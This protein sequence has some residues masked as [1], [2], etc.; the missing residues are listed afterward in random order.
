MRSLPNERLGDVLVVID[1]ADRKVPDIRSANPV[2]SSMT[3][4]HLAA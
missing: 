3:Q 4:E 1:R 2:G